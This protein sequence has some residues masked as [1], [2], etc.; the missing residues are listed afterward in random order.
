MKVDYQISVQ[1]NI[2]ACYHSLPYSRFCLEKKIETMKMNFMRVLLFPTS[3]L[4]SMTI[5]TVSGNDM[6]SSI[7]KANGAI[8]LA[9]E[10]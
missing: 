4:K 2:D 7:F 8:D 1:C 9:I 3:L 6:S 10:K 5:I